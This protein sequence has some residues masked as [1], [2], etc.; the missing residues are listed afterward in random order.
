MGAENYEKLGAPDPVWLEPVPAAQRQSREALKAVAFMY[1]QALQH[2]DG[3]GIYPFRDDCMRIEHAR[4]VV[5]TPHLE[6]YGHADASID[7]TTLKAKAQYELGM[8][9]FVSRIRDRRFL[10]I[11]AERGAVL[12]N[13]VYDFDGDLRTITFAGGRVWKL[14]AYFHTPRSN[15][16]NEAFKI[17]GGSFRYIEMTFIETPFGMRAA[18][19]GRKPSVALDYWP[20]A[21][22]APLR[23]PIERAA[24]RRALDR[25]LDA[26]MEHCPCSLPLAPGF[27]YTENS[28]L[29]EPGM[30]LWQSA[31][32]VRDYGIPLVDPERG[33]AGWFGA[34]DERGL[35]AMLAF[36]I[37]VERGLIT[38]ME[39]IVARPEKPAQ[40]GQLREATFTLFVPP[41]SADLEPDAFQAAP[42]A[43]MRP[44]AAH[45]AAL[46][47]V[48]EQYQ[49][50]CERRDAAA[51]R[52]GKDA[53]RRENG[54]PAADFT[55]S[56]T[57]RLTSLR[58]RRPLVIDAAQGLALDVVLRDNAA[59][60]SAAPP[61]FRSPWTDLHARLFKVERGEVTRLEELVRR[62]PYG[63]GSG[64][65]D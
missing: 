9:A 25:T 40:N 4:Q 53:V 59:L 2:N 33:E 41:L 57:A 61:E 13:A 11:D 14:P 22:R 3:T 44:S 42:Q 32:A 18:W 39:A 23:Q 6:N 12:A 64:W 51:A 63:Q 29:V 16:A 43:L 45:R 56:P 62:L 55:D 21:I 38:E 47:T 7:F 5:T 46:A 52:L 20:P 19:S 58:G 30:G 28:I 17:L 49:A 54:H 8:M 37:R 48:L 50:A 60:S 34:L 24:L 35:F 26:L 65:D 36:R 10:V 31:R 1:F 27:R 15:H